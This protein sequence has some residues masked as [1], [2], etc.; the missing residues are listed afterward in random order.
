M[1]SST[2][3]KIQTAA[4]MVASL[5]QYGGSVSY[6]RTTAAPLEEMLE[7]IKMQDAALRDLHARVH[8]LEHKVFP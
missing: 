3:L 8:E 6:N 4:A 1:S 5:R 2:T 7:V